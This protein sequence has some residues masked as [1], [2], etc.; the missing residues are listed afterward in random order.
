M[1]AEEIRSTPGI[2]EVVELRTMH[3]GPESVIVAARVAFS[4]DVSAD[5]AEDI[6]GDIDQR[7]RDRMSI[8]PHVFIDP[9]QT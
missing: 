8:Q 2:D 9:T 7:L 1:I 6:S 3:L 5:G 4:D